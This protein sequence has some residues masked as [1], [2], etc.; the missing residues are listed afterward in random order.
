MKYKEIVANKLPARPGC[1]RIPRWWLTKVQLAFIFLIWL[2]S[3][4]TE[5]RAQD[6]LEQLLGAF[7]KQLNARDYRGALTNVEAAVRLSPNSAKALF[8]RALV[9]INLGD[10]KDAIEDCEKV[11][12][13]PEGR[14]MAVYARLLKGGALMASGDDT[15]AIT[16]YD[17]VLQIR[18][19]IPQALHYRAK[20]LLRLGRFPEAEIAAAK[21]SSLD[22]AY[23]YAL[24]IQGLAVECQGRAEDALKL[25]ET[26]IDRGTAKRSRVEYINLTDAAIEGLSYRSLLRFGNGDLKG[27][28]EDIDRAMALRPGSALADRGFIRLG[29]KSW[30]DAAD[31]F[32]AASKAALSKHDKEQLLLWG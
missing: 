25:Y 9:R 11:L 19:D 18:P 4:A 30:K 26:S 10:L 16:E 20:S 32:K 31:D 3:S 28:L 2:L 5:C 6:T 8:G 1:T 23:P 15:S 7:E 27:A 21:A 22:A 14:S 24:A 29:S 17:L 12:K 13:L